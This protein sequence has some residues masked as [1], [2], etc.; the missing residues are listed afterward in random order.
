MARYNWDAVAD[1][2]RPVVIQPGDLH[3]VTDVGTTIDRIGPRFSFANGFPSQPALGVTYFRTAGTLP[4]AVDFRLAVPFNPDNLA[5]L[6]NVTTVGG[7]PS[8]GIW[9]RTDAQNTNIFNLRCAPFFQINIVTKAGAGATTTY[10]WQ[11][12]AF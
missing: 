10:V 12:R 8:I 9:P 4:T 2:D 11:I 1:R 6:A 5:Q 3:I 7:A